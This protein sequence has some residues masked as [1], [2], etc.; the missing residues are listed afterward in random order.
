MIG[1]FNLGVAYKNG[2]GVAK[3]LAKSAALYQTACAGGEMK[4]CVNLSI[5]YANGIGVTKDLTKAAALSKT[6][7]DAG[8]QYGC[9]ILEEITKALGE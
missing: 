8:N 9:S 1:C 6:A 2:T 4:G 5:A 7:C 3:D